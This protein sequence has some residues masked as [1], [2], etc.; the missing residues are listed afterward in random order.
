MSLLAKLKELKE[1]GVITDQEI[2]E[3]ENIVSKVDNLSNELQNMEKYVVQSKE[4]VSSVDSIKEVLKKELIL[5]DEFSIDDVVK[6]IKDGKNS[7]V[8]KKELEN[9]QEIIK[10]NKVDFENVKKQ[11]EDQ[12]FNKTLDN[13]IL[14]QGADIQAVSNVALN[15]ILGEVK[16]GAVI[17]DGRLIFKDANGMTV[18]R[19]G[20]PISLKDKIEYLKT[21]AEYAVFFKANVN[22][23]S[24][25]QNN[26]QN[27]SN[28]Y[29]VTSKSSSFS[30]SMREKAAKLGVSIPTSII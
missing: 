5:D 2:S 21:D 22:Q 1:K 14:K 16:K 10:K 29:G 15:V 7:S 3:Y 30:K 24:G 23:G 6:K 9:L 27:G 20:E 8:D 11:Y 4:K 12:L 19:D 18:R 26:T 17:E 28:G 25:M 13:E